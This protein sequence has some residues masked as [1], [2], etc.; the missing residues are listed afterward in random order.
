MSHRYGRQ[1]GATSRFDPRS[2]SSRQRSQPRHSATAWFE[3]HRLLAILDAAQPAVVSVVA[4]AGY[5]KTTLLS[6]WVERQTGPV[7]WLTIDATDND[8]V[9]LMTYLA[10]AFDRVRPIRGAT[11]RGVSG[12][13]E[14]SCRSACRCS[15]LSFTLGLSPD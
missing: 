1:R 7:A 4:P 12:G 3:R 15:Y 9:V 13:S 11:A 8:P 10:T 6:Q 2:R 14:R 5:G